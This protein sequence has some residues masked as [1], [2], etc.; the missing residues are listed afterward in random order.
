MWLNADRCG[1]YL[2]GIEKVYSLCGGMSGCSH[3]SHNYTSIVNI[4]A[5]SQFS[6]RLSQ[7]VGI[8]DELE[9]A[10]STTRYC[11]IDWITVVVYV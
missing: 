3:E 4:I 7:L 9:K 8:K 5:A 10:A 6:E 1:V 11:T 2:V